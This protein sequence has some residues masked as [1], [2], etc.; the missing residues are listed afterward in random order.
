MASPSHAY[1]AR[2]IL[3]PDTRLFGLALLYGLAVSVLTLAVPFSVQI[4]VDTVAHTGVLL[5]VTILALI[6]LGMLLFYVLLNAL[7]IYV[8]DLFERQFYFRVA[9]EIALRALHAKHG[10]LESVN[11]EDLFNR[12]FDIMTVKKNVPPLITSGLAL[13]FQM[14]VGFAVVSLYHPYFLVFSLVYVTI[15]LLVWRLFHDAA[16]RTAVANSTE[17]YQVAAWIELLARQDLF[18]KARAHREYAIA[19][20]RDHIDTYVTTH[21]EHFHYTFAQAIGFL[22]LYAV[23]SATLLGVGGALVVTGELS[24]GQLVAA[25]LILSAVFAGVMRVGYLLRLYY[26]LM[27][28][29]QKLGYLYRIPVEVDQRAAPPADLPGSVCFRNTKVQEYGRDYLLDFSIRAG[30]VAL[31]AT[32]SSALVKAC[33]EQLLDM[34][35]AKGGRVL[36]GMEPVT[37]LPREYLRERVQLI[38]SATIPHTTIA[39]YLALARPGV[40]RSQM[41]DCLDLAGLTRV[42]DGLEHELDER[43]LGDGYPLSVSETLRLRLVYALLAQPSVLVISPLMDSVHVAYRDRL[44]ESLRRGGRTT[45]LY[46]SNRRDLANMS[47]YWLLTPT[48]QDCHPT[49]AALIE[50]EAT[51]LAAEEL[52]YASSVVAEGAPLGG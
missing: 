51:W 46:F 23:G 33:I 2:L 42:V 32:S 20:S 7:Q 8:I 29:L 12:Y 9:S 52:G 5:P 41:R 47:E 27:A 18:F 40:T 10:Y 17:K 4:L 11:R 30:S 35:E 16:M 37:D 50:A 3:L 25:E 38:D 26:E 34:R 43:L 14:I 28:A 21:R 45:V 49:L 39:E 15:A 24:L 44:L 36:L 13:I 48:R 6:L 1:L 31:L 22:L 19:R